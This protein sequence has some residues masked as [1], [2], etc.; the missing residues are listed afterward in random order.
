MHIHKKF[1]LTSWYRQKAEAKAKRG[2]AFQVCKELEEGNQNRRRSCRDA[3]K[4][5]FRRFFIRRKVYE[6]QMDRKA[7]QSESDWEIEVSVL[8]ERPQVV[9]P[10]TP[11]WEEEFEGLLANSCQGKDYP[12]AFL[13]T[14]QADTDL[15]GNLE[16]RGF[17]L[18]PRETPDDRSNNT[19]SLNRNLQCSL[20]LLLEK[21]GQWHFPSS[22]L[23]EGQTLLDCAKATLSNKISRATEFWCPSHCPVAA[24]LLPYP[25]PTAGKFGVKRFYMKF[26]YANG[27]F[28]TEEV[29]GDFAWLDRREAM[30]KMKCE[31][32]KKFLSYVL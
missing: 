3:K 21:D 26:E 22:T 15:F 32:D 24:E 27:T 2:E 28:E 14:P 9:I 10:D 8:L 4:S 29:T 17:V 18:L 30:E 1:F 5:E 13:A 31:Q 25:K 20:Y 16:K 7:R 6:E 23:E 19:Q 12:A 11:I